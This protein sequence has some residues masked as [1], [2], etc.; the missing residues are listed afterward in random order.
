MFQLTSEFKPTGDQPQ[1]IA[2][3]VEGLQNGEQHQT[4]LGVTGSGK[5]FTIA[6][7]IQQVQKP[8]LILSHNKTL[9]AQLYGEFQQFFP[10]NAVEY[11]ISYY[12]YYQPEAYIPSTNTY[13]EKDLA[14]NDEIEK[15]RLR[16]TSALLS[17]RRDVIVVASV[18]CIYGIAN[19]QEFGKNVLHLKVGQ[20]ITRNQFL[21]ALTNILYSRTEVDFQ[22]GNFRVK[23][24]TVDVFVAYADF[25]YRIYF[26]DDEIENIQIIDPS[27]GKKQSDE[28]QIAIYPA[29][30]FVTGQET[31]H[32]AI[33]E[34]QDDL[35]EQIKLFEREGKLEEAMR[36]KERTEFDLEM[37]RELG[38]CSGIE[39][40]SRYFDNR[41]AGQRPFCLLDYFPK[42][43]LLVIDESHVTIPQLRAMYAGDRSRKTSLVEYGFRLPAALDNRPLKFDEFEGLVNQIIYVSATP[44]KYELQNSDGVVVEQVI[45]PT[46]LLD[47]EIIIRPSLHQIDDLLDEIDKTTQKGGRVLVTTLTKRMAEELSKYLDKVGVKGR[48]IHSEVKTLDR[49]EILR[50]LR[51]GVFDVLVGVNLLREGLDL[52]EVALVAIMDADK[53]GFLRDERSLIQTIGRAAR[54]SQGRV[55]MYADKI[56]G[57]M[58]RAI[59]ETQRRRKLQTLYNEK[60]GIVPTTVFKSKEAIMEQTKVAN[61]KKT[62]KNYYVEPEEV[63]VFAD[64][65]VRNMK[66][67][68]LEKLLKETQKA[69]EKA[70]KDLDFIEAARLRDELNS[71]KKK[72]GR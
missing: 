28:Q 65:I 13:I 38:Y 52:P 26:F 34:I 48:Y 16:A 35:V 24:D 71:I 10:H 64:P 59:S 68:D 45:R 60:N 44:Q 40:Y 14:I 67:Q 12:D 29:N 56:T 3:L 27:T 8:T 33:Q 63:D 6:N 72:L 17:G 57:S 61:A 21:Y 70:A 53:E 36:L 54:N 41:K 20:R 11:F 62:V 47:P 69:M 46:G 19:P 22:R 49:V 25:A 31:L 43:F 55:I 58:E 4:L 51:L 9:A 23:G 66:E 39:N 7:V 15:L 30:L 5:T 42:D 32:R 2:K 18:S 1:A 37:M 50:E